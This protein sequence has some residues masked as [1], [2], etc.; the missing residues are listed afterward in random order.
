L[1]E[2]DG[3]NK[4]QAIVGRHRIRIFIDEQVESDSVLVSETARL[5]AIVLG[6]SPER[7]YRSLS[8]LRKNP[9]NMRESELAGWAFP[10]VEDQGHRP[11]S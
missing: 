7:P 10:F 2:K 5:V 9:L 6:N 4:L 3:W 11:S 1:N 8:D